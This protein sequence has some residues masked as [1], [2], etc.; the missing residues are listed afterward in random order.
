[1][2]NQTYSG[3]SSFYK[4]LQI[5]EKQALKNPL[6]ELHSKLFFLTYHFTIQDWKNIRTY[7]FY[8]NCDKIHDEYEK[9]QD[10]INIV[11]A[12]LQSKP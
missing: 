6:M 2:T 4:M 3:G 7:E 9:K 8:R 12:Y 1:M 10:I 11:K 5:F